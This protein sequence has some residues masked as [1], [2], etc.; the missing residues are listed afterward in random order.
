MEIVAILSRGQFA[1]LFTLPGPSNL[2]Q[3]GP[4][5]EGPCSM[6]PTPDELRDFTTVGSVFAWV[7][8]LGAAV[9]AFFVLHGHYAR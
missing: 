4:P 9:D 6:E 2:V 8:F 3:I 5:S 7:P 1:T